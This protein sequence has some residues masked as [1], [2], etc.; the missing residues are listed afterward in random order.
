MNLIKRYPQA[1]FW[2]IAWAT[3]FIGFYMDRIDPSHPW[4]LLLYGTFLGGALVSGI[5]DGRQGLR[6]YLSRI[7]RWQVGIKWY[8]I[9]L[10]LP[11]AIRLAAF[12]L[13]SATGAILSQDYQFP[14][15]GDL[16]IGF[17]WPSFLG[18]ALAEEPGFRGF[19]LPRLQAGRSALYASLILGVLHSIWHLPL[20]ITGSDPPYTVL[21]V[22]AGAIINTWLFNNTGGSVLINMLLHASVDVNVGVF[23][24]L[25]SGQDANIHAI[26]QAAVFVAVAILIVVLSGKELGR[27]PAVAMKSIP[28]DQPLMAK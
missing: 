17:F 21:I 8:L 19:A 14:A 3:A 22:I 12:G 20:L 25:F 4:I 9:A 23:N 10:F 1:A 28:A 11:V 24:G 7:V 5:A 13:N 27:K 16:L 26:W 15:W 2:L 6:I 18:I